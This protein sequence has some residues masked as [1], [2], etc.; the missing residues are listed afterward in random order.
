MRSNPDSVMNDNNATPM[1]KMAVDFGLTFLVC[2]FALELFLRLVFWSDSFMG[3]TLVP[4]PVITDANRDSLSRLADDKTSYLKFDPELGWKIKVNGDHNNGFY[5]SNSFGFRSSRE[6]SPAPTRKILRIITYGDSFT[7]CDDVDNGSTWQNHMELKGENIEVLNFGVMGYG[8]DQALIH[9]RNTAARWKPAVAIMGFMV[10]NIARNINRFPPFRAP[11]NL[12][13]GKP[14]FN[15]Q[16]NE[17]ELAPAPPLKP[18]DYIEKPGGELLTILSKNDDVFDRSAYE[19]GVFGYL[20]TT[21]LVKTLLR[22]YEVKKRKAPKWVSF[23]K[24]EEYVELSY[25]LLAQFSEEAA[26]L[27]AKPIVVIFP[28]YFALKD[29]RNNSTK[30]WDPLTE[31][32][33]KGGVRYVDLTKSLSA[34]LDKGSKIESHFLPHYDSELNSVVADSLL[35]ALGSFGFYESE[36]DSREADPVD[37]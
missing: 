26:Q 12:P 14:R 27:G 13:L 15:L 7:H 8:T 9:F 31:K 30:V 22:R 3:V 32:L 11:G 23:Y 37:Y 16:N 1:A 5:K 36:G 6:Y 28:D 33:E 4:Y 25:R 18:S 35:A 34:Y 21:R 17:L 19:K 20:Y 24:N 29:Y 10:D 2:V